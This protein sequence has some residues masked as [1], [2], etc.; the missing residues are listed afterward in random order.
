MTC[1]GMQACDHMPLTARPGPHL[2][3][4]DS[5]MSNALNF[6]CFMYFIVIYKNK[7]HISRY[8]KSLLLSSLL[9]L[10]WFAKIQGQSG[11]YNKKLSCLY[12]IDK[13]SE[14]VSY[15]TQQK[16]T[17]Q[18]NEYLLRNDQTQD[19]VTDLRQGALEK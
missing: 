2:F 3:T 4:S 14:Y 15:N 9:L 5:T 6:L 8:M 11:L 12:P 1:V 7:D 19:P 18:V 10:F 17:L 13:G 16:V